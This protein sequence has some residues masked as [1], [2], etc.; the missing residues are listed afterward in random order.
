M[1]TLRV[2]EEKCPM[3]QN[4]ACINYMKNKKINLKKKASQT[5]LFFSS[6]GLQV[7]YLANTLPRLEEFIL[8]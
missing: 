6:R 8:L 7:E 3:Y 1:I 5:V 4:N 2:D